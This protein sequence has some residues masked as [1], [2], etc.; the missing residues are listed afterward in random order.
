MNRQNI[1]TPAAHQPTVTRQQLL[2]AVNELTPEEIRAERT[3]RMNLA[4]QHIEAAQN[5]MASACAEL[6]T[7][8]GAIP[9]WKASSSLT[10]KIKAFWYR[11]DTLRFSGKCKLDQM[12]IEVLARQK[13]GLPR[14]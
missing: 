5:H 2:D 1:D 6:S 10:D 8:V 4:L 3:R 11:V 14:F 13:A 9:V 7:L 12:H